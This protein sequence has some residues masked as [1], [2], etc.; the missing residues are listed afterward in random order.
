MVSEISSNFQP[1]RFQALLVNFNSRL[2]KFVIPS[3]LFGPTWLLLLSLELKLQSLIL[4][5]VHVCRHQLFLIRVPILVL[6]LHLHLPHVT[7]LVT[8]QLRSGLNEGSSERM[9]R[10]QEQCRRLVES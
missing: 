8:A 5:L 1:P 7:D 6:P 4:V 9:L 2:R 10:L 3:C